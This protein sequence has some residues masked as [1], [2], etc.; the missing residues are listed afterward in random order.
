MTYETRVLSITVAA[1]LVR[2][3]DFLSDPRN[4]P[5]WA[6]GL[7]DG[8]TAVVEDSPAGAFP[9]LWKASTPAGEATVRFTRAN[10]YGV[11]DHWV[12]LPDGTTVYV[13]LRAVANGSGTEV[14][15]MLF[16]LPSM[17]DRKFEEDAQWVMKDLRCL[18]NVLESRG[19][20]G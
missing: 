13:P 2:V 1:A 14:S 8:L 20:E 16:R 6:S 3:S 18:K 10:D 17:D 15:L 11:A 19:K 4:F 12:F 5:K 9:T 7:A